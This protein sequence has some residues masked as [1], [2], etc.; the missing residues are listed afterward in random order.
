MNLKETILQFASEG[1]PRTS[2]VT[3]VKEGSPAGLSDE[4]E[5]TLQ[6]LIDDGELMEI[7]FLTPEYP[8]WQSII[9]PKGSKVLI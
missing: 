1:E 9:L 6:R 8:R 2:L 3:S 5:Q 7:K 4:I